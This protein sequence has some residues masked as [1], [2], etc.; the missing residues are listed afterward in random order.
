MP[1]TRPGAGPNHCRPPGR[2]RRGRSDH[3]LQIGSHP[4]PRHPAVRVAPGAVFRDAA[5]DGAHR[6]PATSPGGGCTG[7]RCCGSGSLRRRLGQRWRGT[8]GRA[9]GILISF[10]Y[11]LAGIAGGA[12]LVRAIGPWLAAAYPCPPKTMCEGP[13]TVQLICM[14]PAPLVVLLFSV[15]GYVL[16]RR[17]RRRSTGEGWATARLGSGKQR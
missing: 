9:R 11:P 7:R 12:L 2:R 14:Y 6:V 4:L 10:L 3:P 1:S 13:W 16:Q 8:C 17:N 5:R 15:L